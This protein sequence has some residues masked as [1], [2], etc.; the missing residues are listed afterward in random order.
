MRYLVGLA[1]ALV[2][3]QAAAM[4]PD[5]SGLWYD[6]AE[7]GWGLTLAQQGD[8]AF[9][10]LFVYDQANRPVWYFASDLVT[11]ETFAPVPGGPGLFGTLY[12]TTGPW[13]GGTFDP[14][15]VTV[16]SVGTLSIQYTDADHQSLRVDYLIDGAATT[17]S[18]HPQTWVD[19]GGARLAG[20]Y[21][22][23]VRFITK[24]ATTCPDLQVGPFD[25]TQGFTFQVT[26]DTPGQLRLVWGTGS[27]TFC[28]ASGTY[29]QRGQLA[30]ITGS[31]SCGDVGGG[32][33][34]GTGRP[35]QL[36]GLAITTSGFAGAATLQDGSCTYSGHVGGVR[37]PS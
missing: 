24:S 35:L 3:S 15:A 29:T 8:K 1:C 32:L 19:D 11:P 26:V 33:R 2:S 5:P 14:R 16:A 37:L 7:S 25:P 27:D 36:T 21:A 10:V 6:P 12:R 13:F 20:G 9:A 17:R 23:G 28:Q 4:S 22:G 31:L 18:L 34:P 30:S